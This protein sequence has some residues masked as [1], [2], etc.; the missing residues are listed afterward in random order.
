MA[1]LRGLGACQSGEEP[2]CLT[3]TNPCGSGYTWNP[4]DSSCTPT[5]DRINVGNDIL[6]W[7]RNATTTPTTTAKSVWSNPLV[8]GAIGLSLFLLMR[9]R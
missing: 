7:I 6:A 4:A 5:Q 1:I 2:E 9:R 8:W 3:L